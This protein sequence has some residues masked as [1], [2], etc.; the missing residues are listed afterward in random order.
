MVL[1]SLTLADVLSAGACVD[2]AVNWWERNGCPTV[3]GVPEAI[4]KTK[5]DD[6]LSW[7]LRA[8]G[9]NGF[10]GS[11]GGG[12]GYGDGFGSSYGS[13]GDG[14][15][16]GDGDGDGDGDGGDSCGDSCGDG[17]FGW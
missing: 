14:G 2:G 8:L 11:S 13:G 6:D 4:E 16:S 9:L 12:D 10:G 7:V 17:G 1:K 3:V 5:C 15:G